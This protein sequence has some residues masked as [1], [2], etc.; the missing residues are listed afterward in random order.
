MN[1][2]FKVVQKPLILDLINKFAHG[3]RQCIDGKVLKDDTKVAGELTGGARI[4]YVFNEVFAPQLMSI[5]PLKGLTPREICFAIRN[6]TG[7][8][9]ALFIPE[10][11]FELLVKRQI[12][13]LER[14]ALQCVDHVFSELQRMVAGLESAEMAR[15]EKLREQMMTVADEYLHTCRVPT[16]QMISDMLAIENAY[17]NTSHPD[18]AKAIEEIRAA[19]DKQHRQPS[20]SSSMT[21]RPPSAAASSSSSSGSASASKAPTMAQLMA[22]AKFGDGALT[23]REEMEV[24]WVQQLLVS[25]FAIVRTNIQDAVPKAIMHLLVNESKKMQDELTIKLFTEGDADQLLM[26]SPECA[27][28]RKALEETVVTLQKA[29]EILSSV[30]HIVA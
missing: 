29:K 15:F 17:I 27:A 28:R 25:Y 5:D 13:G 14:P 9:N 18:F 7:P 2:D 24:K 10:S 3:Y 4:N 8:R 20:A 19:S 11:A 30:N 16:K 23:E 22:S 21:K 26:E 12:A 1:T 6:A